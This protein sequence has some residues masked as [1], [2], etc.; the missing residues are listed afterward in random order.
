MKILNPLFNWLINRLFTE[1]AIEAAKAKLADQ[2]EIFFSLRQGLKEIEAREEK[3]RQ[4]EEDLRIRTQSIEEQRCL[5]EAWRPF[6]KERK[7]S[8]AQERA[9]VDGMSETLVEAIEILA[10]ERMRQLSNKALISADGTPAQTKP[11][12]T[13]L[14]VNMLL[15]D[16]IEAS[17]LLE[18][19]RERDEKKRTEQAKREPP[20]D[21]LEPRTVEF[22]YQNPKSGS[23]V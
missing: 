19:K 4:R 20:P 18:R 23:S 8:K 16:I 12:W 5:A 6:I 21:G 7:L 2:Q 14:G 10:R 15:A 3:T 17:K 1:D 22:L 9:M 13:A 11:M